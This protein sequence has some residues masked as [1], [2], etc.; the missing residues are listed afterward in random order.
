ML[1]A[2]NKITTASL[3]TL[4]L[5]AFPAIGS[6]A[7]AQAAAPVRVTAAAQ[8]TNG[9]VTVKVQ[10]RTRSKLA[11]RVSA[12]AG[13]VA[14]GSAAYRVKPRRS[15]T[16]GLSLGAAARRKLAADRSL[17][18]RVTATVR[19]RRSVTTAI[20]V[21]GP[22]A[23]PTPGGQKG[24]GP[25]WVARTDSTGAY[26]DFAFTLAGDQVS[27]TKRPMA[28]LQC[29]ENGGSY[30]TYGSWELFQPAGP[31]TLGAQSQE[32]TESTPLVNQMAGSSPHS[33]RY[34]LRTS[35][36]GD[37]I[38]GQ[39]YMSSAWSNYDYYNNEIVFVNCFG[40]TSFDAVQQ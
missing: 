24:K 11:G 36:S 14:A 26:D 4:S 2:P 32:M 33:V 23:A 12:K 10:N 3:F 1:L 34:Q 15:A 39:L 38:S 31:W 20:T 7:D 29:A 35:R 28:F 21:T 8:A 22:G 30:D 37:G 5:L 40:T 27:V 19:G 17:R 13:K 18:L 16:V 6:A 25:N 9:T